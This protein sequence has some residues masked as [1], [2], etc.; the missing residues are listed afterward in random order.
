MFLS[1]QFRIICFSFHVAFVS[2][3]LESFIS[4]LLTFMT[5]PLLKMIGWLFLKMLLKLCLL[6]VVSWLD[7]DILFLQNYHVSD[8]Y[9]HDLILNTL[10]WICIY[11]TC[12]GILF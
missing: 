8:V 3:T 11:K 10:Y 6:D 5:L 1:I 7:T 12:F 2:F 9:S 4:L